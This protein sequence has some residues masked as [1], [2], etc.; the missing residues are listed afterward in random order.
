LSSGVDLE[1][2]LFDFDMSCVEC[3]FNGTN[4]VVTPRCFL[5]LLTGYNFVS[6]LS[7]KSVKTQLRVKKYYQR[8]WKTFVYYAYDNVNR[9]QE[10][11]HST[12]IPNPTSSVILDLH[13]VTPTNEL[14]CF[15]CCVYHWENNP[16]DFFEPLNPGQLNYVPNFNNTTHLHSLISKHEFPIERVFLFFQQLYLYDDETKSNLLSVPQ[17]NQVIC[18]KCTLKLMAHIIQCKNPIILST[19][20]FTLNE[21][22]SFLCNEGDHW[23]DVIDVDISYA[24]SN[25]VYEIHTHKVHSNICFCIIG[26]NNITLFNT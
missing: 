15:V 25:F 3:A 1:Q 6:A 19:Q 4:V 18:Y 7:L 26:T 5:T 22:K 11:Q 14:S 10:L 9:Y 8:Q 23:N 13:S 24:V 21:Y 20:S 2:V 17:N 12:F 16:D